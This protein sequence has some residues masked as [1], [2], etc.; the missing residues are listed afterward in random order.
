MI[1]LT[2]AEVKSVLKGRKSLY[3]VHDEVELYGKVDDEEHAGPAVL[4]V[5]WHHHIRKTTR[6]E[7]SHT[8][9]NQ[10]QPKNIQKMQL[11]RN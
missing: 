11:W 10:K 2:L 3:Q 9:Q 5:R 8:D 6:E 7:F 4:R 1:A